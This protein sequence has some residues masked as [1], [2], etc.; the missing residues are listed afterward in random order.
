MAATP[1]FYLKDKK[2]KESTLIVFRWFLNGKIFV[3]S[4]GE[5]VKPDL[6]SYKKERVLPR[7]PDAKSINKTLDKIEAAAKSAR[8]ELI[9]EK[10][11]IEFVD[12]K[13]A[14]QIATGKRKSTRELFGFIEEFTQFRE[15]RGMAKGTI[16]GD[17]QLL[18]LLKEYAKETGRQE[19]R[20]ADMDHSF[21][22]AFADFLLEKDSV[23]SNAYVKKILSR[24]TTFLNKAVQEKVNK[25]SAYRVATVDL[26][27]DESH[28]IYIS[29][30]ELEKLYRLDLSARPSHEQVRDIFLIGAYTGLRVSDWLKVSFDNVRVNKGQRLLT[31]IA[32]KTREE[33]YIPL[34]QTVEEI[35]RKYNGQ[36]PNPTEAHINRTLKEIGKT[37]DFLNDK[38]KFI[39]HAGHK[40]TEKEV[41]RWELLTT[42]TARRSFATNAYLDSWEVDTIRKITGHKSEKIFF[43]YIRVS[44]KEAATLQAKKLSEQEDENKGKFSEAVAIATEN[45]TRWGLTAEEI[46]VLERIRAKVNKQTKTSPLRMV[47]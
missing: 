5:Q 38:V 22:N 10:G 30:G 16:N 4:T 37:C 3:Y 44:K 33:L 25:Y 21:Y 42:H 34:H 2:S 13:M 8:A 24:L 41:H 15:S 32:Q 12:L 1:H 28:A 39:R 29:K 46:K 27:K 45:A 35:L 17:K 26:K 9:A 18:R 14:I 47:N 31:V 19:F 20:F 23:T 36:L 11:V 7:H 40:R 6:W 43:E